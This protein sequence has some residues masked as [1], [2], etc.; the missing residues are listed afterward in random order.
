[1]LVHLTTK[2]NDLSNPEVSLYTSPSKMLWKKFALNGN[3]PI[4]N[5]M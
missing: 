4:P 5:Y 3:T 1:M 2:A